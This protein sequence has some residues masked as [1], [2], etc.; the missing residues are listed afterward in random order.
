MARALRVMSVERG[1]DPRGLALVAFG[2]AGPMHACAL[3]DELAIGRILVPRRSGVLSALGLALADARRDRVAPGRG[4]P[5]A[6]F[7]ELERELGDA[8]TERQADLR[9]RGQGFELTVA[10]DDL[11]ALERRFEEAHERRYGYRLDEPV[12]LIALRL[13][14]LARR[15]TPDWDDEGEEL[16]VPGPAVVDL[17]EATCIV[18]EGWQARS[19][20]HGT[21][22]LER[23]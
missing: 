16:D 14:A 3:A 6:G 1:V 13:T 8:E 22:V 19:A 2:G 11:G 15:E 17:G 12:E 10:A 20:G 18:A 21:L 5:A 9:Y 4:D 23:A 7:A